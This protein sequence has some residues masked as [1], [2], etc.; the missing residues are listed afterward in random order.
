M[1]SAAAGRAGDVAECS[2]GKLTLGL[3]FPFGRLGG[4]RRVTKGGIDVALVVREGGGVGE[5]VGPVPGGRGCLGIHCYDLFGQ[6][7]LGC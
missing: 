2:C 6:I 7:I 5:G 1:G 4:E 3:A